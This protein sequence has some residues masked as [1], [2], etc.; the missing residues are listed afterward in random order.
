MGALGAIEVNKLMFLCIVCLSCF[1]FLALVS[2][3]AKFNILYCSIF[4]LA[5][6]KSKNSKNGW[7]ASAV[8]EVGSHGLCV[9]KLSFFFVP[10]LCNLRRMMLA[11]LS[12]LYLFFKLRA[13]SLGQPL[14]DM[15]M[16]VP[17]PSMHNLKTGRVTFYFQP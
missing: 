16:I 11:P 6:P 8:C 4:G 5:R 15:T 2:L 13:G 14:S 17:F 10:C 1:S 3:R 9:D 7:F 12:E